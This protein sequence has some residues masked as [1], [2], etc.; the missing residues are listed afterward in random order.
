MGQDGRLAMA[1]VQHMLSAKYRVNG[2]GSLCR[3]ECTREGELGF[4]PILK[5]SSMPNFAS[6]SWDRGERRNSKL[7]NSRLGQWL[8]D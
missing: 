6:G 3:E 8:R 4:P 2:N 5:R 1:A 7:S